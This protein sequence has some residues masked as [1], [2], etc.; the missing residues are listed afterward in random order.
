MVPIRRWVESRDVGVRDTK[1]GSVAGT[2]R[3]L[4]C[5]CGNVGGNKYVVEKIRGGLSPA[6]DNRADSILFSL[7]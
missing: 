6:G 3:L 1:S 2:M 7:Y 4:G 5:I